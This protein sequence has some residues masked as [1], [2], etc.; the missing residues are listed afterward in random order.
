MNGSLFLSPEQAQSDFTDIESVQKTLIEIGLIAVDK[1]AEFYLC[2]EQFSQLVTFMGCSP[3]LVF[4]PPEDGSDNFCH[5][6][7]HQY[8]KTRLLTGQQTA[9]PRCPACRYRVGNWRPLLENLEGNTALEQWTCPGCHE[10]M[11]IFQLDW[12][13]SAGAGKL[14]IEISNIFPGEAVPADRLLASLQ[15]ISGEKWHYFYLV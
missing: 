8:P 6:R 2:G 7:L 13:Q 11:S 4:E 15:H 5:V 12:R 14:F 9:P 10:N 3:Y 1:V